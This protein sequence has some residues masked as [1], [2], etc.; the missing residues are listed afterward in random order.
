MS[1]FVVPVVLGILVAFYVSGTLILS[2]PDPYRRVAIYLTILA[3]DVAT[4]IFAY[5]LLGP[6]F[7]LV[8]FSFTFTKC[9][10]WCIMNKR[11]MVHANVSED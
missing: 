2:E 7:E 6:T 4:V 8:L 3:S 11:G 9:L 1:L 10:V 5:I